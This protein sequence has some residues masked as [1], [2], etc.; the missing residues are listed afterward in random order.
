MHRP[1]IMFRRKIRFGDGFSRHYNPSSRVK[2][3]GPPSIFSLDPDDTRYPLLIIRTEKDLVSFIY[4]SFGEGEYLVL[5]FIKNKKGFWAFW[6][7]VIS[8]DGWIHS[9]KNIK[10]EKG[11]LEEIESEIRVAKTQ[12]E[13]IDLEEEYKLMADILNS[14]EEI[15]RKNRE[16]KKHSRYGFLPFLIPSGRRGT[17]HTWDEPDE[18]LNNQISIQ[19]SK[20]KDVSEMTLDEINGL[21]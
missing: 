15:E 18:A 4:N 3:R 6:K 14:G 8:S 13:R 7:G 12:E 20:R 10:R 11:I 2:V 21:V 5:G 17:F 16:K 1:K 9:E 19:T